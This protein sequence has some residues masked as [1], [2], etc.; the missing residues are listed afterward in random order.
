MFSICF[1]TAFI[2]FFLLQLSFH[3]IVHSHRHVDYDILHP[4]FLFFFFLKK[5]FEN[6]S[7]FLF[8]ILEICVGI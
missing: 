6:K 3:P 1:A 8:T 7:L 4:F 2:I 5:N